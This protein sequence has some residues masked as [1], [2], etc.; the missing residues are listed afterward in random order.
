M[1]IK[2]VETARRGVRFSDI[3]AGLFAQLG[4]LPSIYA[5]SERF[6]RFPEG[7]R[8]GPP[9]YRLQ[10][11]FIHTIMKGRMRQWTCTQSGL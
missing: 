2:G 8:S 6:R 3:V 9:S 10:K 1:C 11:Y 7:A 5:M 4:V